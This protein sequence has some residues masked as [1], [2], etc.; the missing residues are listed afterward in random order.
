MC[1]SPLT[2]SPPPPPLPP[3]AQLV[4]SNLHARFTQQPPVTLM[5]N[6]SSWHAMMALYTDTCQVGGGGSR[7]GK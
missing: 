2:C 4:L 6:G 7:G 1:H 3:Q 5:S